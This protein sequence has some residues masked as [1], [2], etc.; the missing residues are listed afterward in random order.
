ML[1]YVLMVLTMLYLHLLNLLQGNVS[2]QQSVMSNR[3]LAY[4]K[5]RSASRYYNDDYDGSIRIEG[6]SFVGRHSTPE[7]VIQVPRSGT[8]TGITAIECLR[9]LPREVATL[10]AVEALTC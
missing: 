1:Y 2:Y 8:R 6:F 7:V 9:T 3:E 5:T 10:K 4:R